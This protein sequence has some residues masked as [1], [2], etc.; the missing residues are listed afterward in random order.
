MLGWVNFV[1]LNRSLEATLL[2]GTVTCAVILKM[3]LWT[4]GMIAKYI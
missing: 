2:P 1:V 4:F 3:E